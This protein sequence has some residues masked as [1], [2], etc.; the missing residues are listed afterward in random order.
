MVGIARTEWIFPFLV[1]GNSV[2]L[3]DAAEFTMKM[4]SD[5]REVVTIR[6][7][8]MDIKK[9]DLVVFVPEQTFVDL[10]KN[11]IVLS[12]HVLRN[13]ILAQATDV[14]HKPLNKFT[15]ADVRGQDLVADKKAL[16]AIHSGLAA[17]M[18]NYYEGV[19][20]TDAFTS[21]AFTR[22]SPLTTI[23]LIGDL[24]DVRKFDYAEPL[25]PGMRAKLPAPTSIHL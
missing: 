23:T 19:K 2:R 22:L 17:D 10:D 5:D 12:F 24:S 4:M 8:K 21:L 3:V 7:G 6:M 16:R 14:F 20:A 18:N 13:S 9:G 15:L 11:G 25:R 1:N